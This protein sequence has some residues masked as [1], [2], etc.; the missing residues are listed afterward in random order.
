[1]RDTITPKGGRHLSAGPD[2]VLATSKL[3]ARSSKL[4]TCSLV[5]LEQKHGTSW[6][7]SQGVRVVELRD[8]ANDPE[9]PST[10]QRWAGMFRGFAV[11]L[12]FVSVVT[13]CEPCF[14]PYRMQNV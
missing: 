12:Q 11:G 6:W 14:F 9:Q 3:E 13:T 1:M 5:E 8:F 2:S 4:E 10:H 7:L